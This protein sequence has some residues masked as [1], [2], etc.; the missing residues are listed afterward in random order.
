MS[1]NL[2]RRA[3]TLAF[4]TTPPLLALLLYWPGLTAWFQQDDFAWLGLRDLAK[5]QRGFGWA[6][7]APLS[8]GTIRTLSERVFFMSFS[9][10]FALHPLPYR[11]LAFLTFA[12]SL[13]LLISVCSKLTGSRAAGFGAAILWTANSAVAI[14]LS[15]TSVYYEILCSFVFLLNF[16]LLLRY[17]ETGQRRFYI[18]QCI[19]FVLGFGVLELNVVYPALA[20]VWALCCARHL[21]R[22]IVPLFLISAAYAVLHFALAPLPASGPYKLHLDSGIFSTLFTYWKWALGPSKLILF[23]IQPSFFRSA[24]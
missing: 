4:W 15:W 14:P 3:S 9:A 20:A 12:A 21:L 6:L 16:W 1:H 5:G 8:Q 22:K 13:A 19:T 11:C 24:L 18:A 23:K 17:A 7:F 10:V 2:L